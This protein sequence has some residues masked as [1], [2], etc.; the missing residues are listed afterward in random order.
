MSLNGDMKS[1][2]D[3]WRAF[4]IYLI[5]ALALASIEGRA[6]S[7]EN[8]LHAGAELDI[9]NDPV[10]GPRVE[11]S[12]MRSRYA[13]SRQL[14]DRIWTTQFKEAVD[15]FSKTVPGL[16]GA[17][18]D[19]LRWGESQSWFISGVESDWVVGSLANEV[20]KQLGIE[21]IRLGEFWA[22]SE[23]LTNL[24]RA[25][26]ETVFRTTMGQS[27]SAGR[28]VQDRSPLVR[29][30]C[31][32]FRYDSLTDNDTRPHHLAFNGFV[33]PSDMPIWKTINPLNGFNCRCSREA[34]LASEAARRGWLTATGEPDWTNIRRT[35]SNA[36]R[37]GLLDN[38]GNL[39]GREVVLLDADGRKVKD[40]FPARGFDNA[41]AVAA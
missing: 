3:E 2:G 29:E 41:V 23:T 31:P 35:W 38:T 14:P 15:E 37:A 18:S 11:V 36:I 19:A 7:I 32:I 12:M 22:K 26:L 24:G 1:A 10:S 28:W 30:I 17:M 25:R 20:K 5:R 8:V 40:T 21:G 13:D 27:I 6:L 9:D 34:I 4:R 16:Q 39:T 33:A